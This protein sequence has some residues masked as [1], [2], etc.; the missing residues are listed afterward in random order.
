MID[1]A[2]FPTQ[3]AKRN[4]LI[5]GERINSTRKGVGEAIRRR[6]ADAI[7]REAAMQKA[8]GAHMLDVNCA[9]GGPSEMDDMRWV[10]ETVQRATDGTPLCIDS[11]DPDVLASGLSV[12]KG[13]AIVN[14]ISL[15]RGRAESVLP[16]VASRKAG[17]IALTMDD[18]GLP[19]SV[20]ERIEIAGRIIKVVDSYGISV[21]DLYID[22]LVRPISSEPK[23]ASEFLQAIR[24]IKQMAPVKIICGLSNVSFGLPER[25]LLNAV[26]LAMA[27][28]AGLDAAL[29]DPLNKRMKA[30]VRAADALLGDDEFCMRYIASFREGE[31]LL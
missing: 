25:S 4:M 10:I 28:G 18:N 7:V 31:L 11:P 9:M 6:D 12:H 26:F 30:S 20:S 15:E 27:L 21:E 19:Q 23:Q 14:S 24:E 5:I 17:V 13:R 22:P 29:I 3:N 2:D 8:S 16:A 1:Y